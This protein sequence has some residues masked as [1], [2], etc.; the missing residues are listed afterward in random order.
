M[1]SPRASVEQPAPAPGAECPIPGRGLCCAE[2]IPCVPVWGARSMSLRGPQ[3]PWQ[4]Q[5]S[6]VLTPLALG[7]P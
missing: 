5:V 6:S 3:A 7:L 4:S 1:A 2:E